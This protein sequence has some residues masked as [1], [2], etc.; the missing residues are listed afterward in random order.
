MTKNLL[1]QLDASSLAIVQQVGLCADKLSVTAYLVGGPVRDLILKRPNLDFDFTVEGNG[2]RLA[3]LF[4]EGQKGAKVVKYPAFKTATVFLPKGRAV[5]FVT[6]RK[7]I[8]P[9][10]GAMPVVK[11]SGI[12]DDLFR[13]DFTINAIALGINS[14]HWGEIVDPFLGIKDLKAG[15]IR[16]LHEK[17]FIDDPTRIL[18]AARFEQRLQFKIEPATFKILKH[19]I[20]QGALDSI[21]PQ[22]CFKEYK[23]I[24]QEKNPQLAME[25][26]KTWGALLKGVIHV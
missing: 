21:K 25:R 13:R 5:D 10:P 7:E 26:L 16:I 4:A 1:E 20:A 15:K 14:S 23:K 9:R 18:R 22:R 17:S 24:N 2:M 6:A 3:E 8:Y 19:A 12:H 11:P